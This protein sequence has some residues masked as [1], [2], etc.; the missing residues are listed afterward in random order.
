MKKFYLIAYFNRY[1][2]VK[3]DVYSLD[4][5]GLTEFIRKHKPIAITELNYKK[6]KAYSE[7]YRCEY[8]EC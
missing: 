5:K 6:A 2:K 8:E 3:S 7:E 1:G 4:D